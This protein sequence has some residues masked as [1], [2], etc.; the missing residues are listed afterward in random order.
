MQAAGR[1]S[2]ANGVGA[3]LAARGVLIITDKISRSAGVILRESAMQP[4]KTC[5]PACTEELRFTLIGR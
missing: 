2:Y 4:R 5:E 3:T 1:Q